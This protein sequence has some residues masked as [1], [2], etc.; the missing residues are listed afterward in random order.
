MDFF[1]A[2]F[3]KLIFMTEIANTKRLIIRYFTINDANFIVSLLNSSTWIEF[4]GDKNI[5]TI[6]DAQNY[7]QNTLIKGYEMYGFGL[8]AV[9][10]KNSNTLIGMCG[11]VKRSYLVNVDIGFAIHPQYA[12]NGYGFESATEIVSYSKNV[13]NF[14]VLNAIT[15]EKNIFSINLLQKLGFCFEKN[16]MANNEE[17][18]LYTLNL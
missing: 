4:I 15:L 11:L 17:L 3:F 2:L 10:L 12:H 18:Q 7:L 9:A 1:I 5:Q 6:N 13:L 16:I 8:Y 14:N